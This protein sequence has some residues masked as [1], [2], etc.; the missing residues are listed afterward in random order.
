MAKKISKRELQRQLEQIEALEVIT[1]SINRNESSSSK[2]S[3]LS[4]FQRAAQAQIDE[5]RDVLLITVKVK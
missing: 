4:M 1:G 3:K 5:D 2:K